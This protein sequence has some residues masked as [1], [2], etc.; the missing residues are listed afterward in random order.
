MDF[1]DSRRYRDFTFVCPTEILAYDDALPQFEAL[2]TV[3]FGPPSLRS[4]VTHVSQSTMT[5]GIS[6]DSEYSHL[7]WSTQPRKQGGLGPNLKLPLIADKTMRISRFVPSPH[8]D[9][10]REMTD[11]CA[12]L[13]EF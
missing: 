8:L 11:L 4:F 7:A 12:E 1:S 5:P 10:L 3:I 6:T 13:M 2:N 9:L